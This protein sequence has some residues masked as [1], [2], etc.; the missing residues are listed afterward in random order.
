MKWVYAG[1]NVS[2]VAAQLGCKL[3]QAQKLL[4]EAGKR[5][6]VPAD[7]DLLVSLALWYF[8]RCVLRPLCKPRRASKLRPR[9]ER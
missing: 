9:E 4:S 3:R 6:G 5:V 2:A 7:C 8:R 1:R